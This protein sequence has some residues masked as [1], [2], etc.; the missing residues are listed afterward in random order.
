VRDTL[1]LNLPGPDLTHDE[2]ATAL[3]PLQ[4]SPTLLILD[5]PAAGMAVKS[6]HRPGWVVLAAARSDQPHS[7]RFS[8]YF[9]PALEER[10][11]DIDA[12]GRTSILEAFQWTA[13]QLDTLY[14]DQKLMKSETPL[15][16][17]DGDGTPSQSPW[18]YATTGKDGQHAA[19][20]YVD[21]LPPNATGTPD[22]I[23][24]RGTLHEES[25]HETQDNE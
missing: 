20:W 4:Q 10:L 15:L 6:L 11:G 23:L 13:Q 2:L 3:M 9:V 21:A 1:R 19:Q 8:D 7:P 5:C 18:R 24:S 22:P 14:R 16:E 25:N 12:D 17:D